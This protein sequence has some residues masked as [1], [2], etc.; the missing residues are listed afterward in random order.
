MMPPPR[1]RRGVIALVIVGGGVIATALWARVLH[2]S[3]TDLR[4]F[5]AP[6]FGRWWPRF[7]VGVLLPAAVGSIVV[8]VGPRVARTLRWWP[9]MATA[10]VT[11]AVWSVALSS[12]TGSSGLTRTLRSRYDYAAVL[13]DVRRLGLASFVRT[14]TAHLGDYPTHVKSHPPGLVVVLRSL[15]VVGLRGNGWAAATMIAVAASVPCAIGLVVRGLA[16]P[17]AARA[18][19]PFLVC[20]PWTLLVATVGDGV[21]AA[22]AAWAGALLVLAARSAG[23]GLGLALLAGVVVGLGLYASYGLVPLVV[24]LSVSILVPAHRARLV[25]PVLAGVAVVGLTWAAAGFSWWHGFEGA[26]A[27]YRAGVASHRPY[28]YFAV[29]NL[30][31]F[32]VMLGPAV[33]SSLCRRLDPEVLPIVAASLAAVAIADLSGLSKGEVERIWLPF[34]PFVTIAASR[35]ARRPGAAPWL[36]AQVG[37]ALVLQSVIDWPW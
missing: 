32:A 12:A 24:A 6:F 14:Y 21:F 22:L 27:A 28:T 20:G 33:V 37:T 29:A 16:G 35:L 5:S 15:E 23:R 9:L 1:E 3:G 17:A 36:A 2:R 26:R 13:P 31:V 10:W 8:L 7:G 11:T 30:V 34:V 25:V 19:L 18:L 4:L